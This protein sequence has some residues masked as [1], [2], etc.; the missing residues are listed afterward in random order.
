MREIINFIPKYSNDYNY[1]RSVFDATDRLVLSCGVLWDSISGKEIHKFDQLSF[2]NSGIFHPNGNHVI[3]LI[4]M[5]LQYL[6]SIF[7]HSF[8]LI[9]M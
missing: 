5:N 9:L 7:C 8:V 2:N 3:F 6:L 1:S 4:F